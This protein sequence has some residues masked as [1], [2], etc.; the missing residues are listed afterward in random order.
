MKGHTTQ[1]RQDSRVAWF[2]L[3]LEESSLLWFPWPK[4]QLAAT[5]PHVVSFIRAQ[6]IQG[7][8]G[9]HPVPVRP[10]PG[11]SPWLFPAPRSADPAL[12]PRVRGA[13]R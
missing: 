9:G 7:N 4:V 10:E 13:P 11:P 8:E 2:C 5:V 12:C 6:G 1:G 3:E